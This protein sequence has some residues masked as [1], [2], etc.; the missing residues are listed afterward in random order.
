VGQD[1]EGYKADL[2]LLKI[3]I[4]LPKGLDRFFDLPVGSQMRSV[5][6]V[7]SDRAAVVISD[8]TAQ[9][10]LQLAEGVEDNSVLVV[11]TPTHVRSY[12][13][14]IWV[15]FAGLHVEVGY[16]VSS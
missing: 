2:R 15:R 1:K 3:R 12:F 5:A 16:R 6:D 9:C 8:D 4:F 14:L 13:D 7:R 10:N 11:V